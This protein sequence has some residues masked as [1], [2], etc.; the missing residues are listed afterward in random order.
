[1]KKVS[2]VL[3]LACVFAAFASSFA[4]AEEPLYTV[5]AQCLECHGADLSGP[6]TKKVDFGV[7][8][9]NK[10]TACVK[11]HW[12]PRHTTH[13]SNT[14][15]CSCHGAFSQDREDLYVGLRS[16]PYGYFSYHDSPDSATAAEL[17]EIHANGSWP[18]G[19][20]TINPSSASFGSSPLC[21]SCHGAAS[22][23]SCH[24][25]PAAH[26]AHVALDPAY[27]PVNRTVSP[28][29]TASQAGEDTRY[30]EQSY[31]INAACHPSEAAQTA[32]LETVYPHTEL[33][34]T[35][36]TSRLAMFTQMRSGAVAT[37]QV[38]GKGDIVFY[39]YG[40][41]SGAIAEVTVDSDQPVYVDTV[42][43][44]T[45]DGSTVENDGFRI[46]KDLPYGT[47]TVTIRNTGLKSALSTG[48]DV[49]VMS[50][51]ISDRDPMTGFIPFCGS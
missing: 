21:G 28:G 37:V 31:C 40:A 51:R 49:L 47:H 42:M 14:E 50:V 19:I 27:S 18:A 36:T 41:N 48:F 26:G 6:A 1:M 12:Q 33:T 25:S 34:Y 20:A 29:A 45:Y 16:T 24:E 17:H 4:F 30:S 11:C 38:V 15:S 8:A 5:N 23:E 3:I 43:V 22:C 46:A 2:L 32:R 9:V 10:E 35:G 39:A 7:G 13:A 44:D